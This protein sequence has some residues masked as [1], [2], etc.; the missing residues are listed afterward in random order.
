MSDLSSKDDGWRQRLKDAV[1]ASGRSNADIARACGL[2]RGY[3]TN[4]FKEGKEPTI[5]N[6]IAIVNELGISV[7][8]ILYGYDV[9]PETEEILGLIEKNPDLRAGILQ[10]LRSQAKP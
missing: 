2:N 8:K 10:I 6:L 3:F 5:G 4:I 9:S 7:S 1:D